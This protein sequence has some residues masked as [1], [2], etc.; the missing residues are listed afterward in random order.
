[1]DKE[2]ELLLKGISLS[3]VDKVHDELAYVITKVLLCNE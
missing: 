3:N 1:M 2:K